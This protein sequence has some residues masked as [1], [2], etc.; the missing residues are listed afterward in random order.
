MRSD[1]MEWCLPY[2]AHDFMLFISIAFKEL[3]LLGYDVTQ[4]LKS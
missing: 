2:K 3:C 4:P 1:V